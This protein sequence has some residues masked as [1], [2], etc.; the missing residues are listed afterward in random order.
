[1]H[2]IGAQCVV[3]AHGFQSRGREETVVFVADADGERVFEMP[4]WK[5]VDPFTCVLADGDEQAFAAAVQLC[6]Q[7][8]RARR[9]RFRRDSGQLQ[10][11]LRA[12]SAAHVEAM[13]S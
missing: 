5:A 3:S 8:C 13:M 6:E 2:T 11:A 10:Q 12:L 7:H 4:V 1:M 9:L